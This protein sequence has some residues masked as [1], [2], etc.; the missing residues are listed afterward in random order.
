M[1]NRLRCVPNLLAALIA[2]SIPLMAS[3]DEPQAGTDA[4]TKSKSD[5]QTL[6]AV[7]V[8]GTRAT[9]RTE[10]ESL[11]PIDVLSPK[12]LGASGYNDLGSAL[13]TLLPELASA[14]GRASRSARSASSLACRVASFQA[15]KLSNFFS[16]AYRGA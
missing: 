5:Q 6:N 8:T 15:R 12:D 13:N 1:S 4:T 10:A 16:D 11:S 2:V 9:N 7:I 3:A 14:V